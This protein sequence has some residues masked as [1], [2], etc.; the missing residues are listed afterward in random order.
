MG[1]LLPIVFAI[2]GLL[3]GAGA[4]YVLRPPPQEQAKAEQV[5]CPPTDYASGG[6]DAEG[7]EA[8]GSYPVEIQ[9][10]FIEFDNQFIVPV[11]SDEAITSLVVLSLTLEVDSVAQELIYERMPKL[12]DAFLNVL[13][14]HSSAGGF[15]TDF[16]N[17]RGLDAVRGLLKE[18]AVGIVGV[19][20]MDVLIVDLLKKDV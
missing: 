5:D 18:T 20:V 15:S 13:F 16:V 19:Q 3:G 4:G 10:T 7:N 1:K 8:A 14:D 6:Q 2:I 12:R 9:T 17:G 11:A